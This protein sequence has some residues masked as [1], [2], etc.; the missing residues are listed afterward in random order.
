LKPRDKDAQEPTWRQP[1]DPSR[2]TP[3]RLQSILDEI[4]AEITDGSPSKVTP[5]SE[6]EQAWLHEKHESR[7][8]IHRTATILSGEQLLSFKLFFTYL[9]KGWG[10]LYHTAKSERRLQVEM[11]YNDLPKVRRALANVPVYMM[12]DDHEVTDDWNLNPMWKDRVYT[13]PLGKTVLRN[14]ILAYALFQGWGNDPEYFESGPATE[15]LSLVSQVFP[16]GLVTP[17]TAEPQPAERIS[18]LFGLDGSA[19]PPIRWNY[20]VKC[21]RHL[22]IAL[23]NRTRRSFVSRLGPP[24]NIAIP[25]I[26]EQIPAGPL[27]AGIEVAIVIAP[28]PVVGPP[29]FDELV[30][31]LSYRVYDMI[32]FFQEGDANLKNMP[33]TNPDAIEAWAF[34]PKTFETLLKRLEPLRRIVLLS[35]DVHNGSAQFLSYWKKGDTQPTRFA[36]FTSSGVRNVMPGFLRMVDRSFAVVQRIVRAKLGT[37][38]LGWNEKSPP[39]LNLPPNNE[40]VMPVL[41]SKLESSP[42]LIPGTGWPEA[43]TVARPPDWSWRAHVVF[44]QRPDAERPEIARPAVLPSGTNP[45]TVSG[46]RQ[47]VARHVKQ[48][49]ASTH[50]RQILMT[51]NIGRI[52]FEQTAEALNVVQELFAV[53]PQAADPKKA[54]IYAVHRIQIAALGSAKIDEPEPTLGGEG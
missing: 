11:F 2:L 38:R 26:A 9:S 42:I 30:A 37:T 23:D 54:E 6:Q 25:A 5:K 50:G 18:V 17:P 41:R 4:N 32:S 45:T 14:G 16:Q 53:H 19:Q 52:R 28:L 22:L 39:P 35:G 15:L 8:K 34:D 1:L 43:A 24:G 44:D 47:L 46:Y 21:A 29:V 33:G 49:K 27:D 10:G 31:P 51:N 13:N 48:F 7:R 3:E 12:L 20:T 40:G 36:Q